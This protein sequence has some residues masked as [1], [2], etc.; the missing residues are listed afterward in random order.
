MRTWLY[1]LGM[2]HRIGAKGQV[3]IP[4]EIRDRAGLRPGTEVDFE[5]QEHGVTLTARPRPRPRGLANRFAQ[6]GMA[7]RLLVDRAQE[8]R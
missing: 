3:V 6:S 5:F 2:S 7:R 1:F 8:P 4:K